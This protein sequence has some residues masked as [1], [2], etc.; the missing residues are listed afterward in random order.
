MFRC[1]YLSVFRT[2]DFLTR[3]YDSIDIKIWAKKEAVVGLN[4][5]KTKV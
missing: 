3:F 4:I 5:F 2:P 1:Y